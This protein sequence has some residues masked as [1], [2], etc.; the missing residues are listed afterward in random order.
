M[1]P[2]VYFFKL[3][4][5]S[6]PIR[7]HLCE[8][9]HHWLQDKQKKRKKNTRHLLVLYLCFYHLTPFS[10]RHEAWGISFGWNSADFVQVIFGSV[11]ETSVQGIRNHN[12]TTHIFTSPSSN[13]R[14]PSSAAS[15][16]HTHMA[17]LA[18]SL[19]WDTNYVTLNRKLLTR[20]L[21]RKW[22]GLAAVR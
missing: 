22:A 4:N 7:Q 16:T 5:K 21:H 10:T 15:H 9:L 11:I 6:F 8:I 12:M 3:F 20:R 1:R 14:A 18:P 13:V 17:V 2:K 19:H